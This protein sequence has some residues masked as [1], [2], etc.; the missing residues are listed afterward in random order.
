MTIKLIYFSL[1]GIM[2]LCGTL[3]ISNPPVQPRESIWIGKGL[4][5]IANG[6][7]GSAYQQFSKALTLG[8]ANPQAIRLRHVSDLFRYPYQKKNSEELLEKYHLLSEKYPD[9]IYLKIAGAELHLNSDMVVEALNLN[10]EVSVKDDSHA[11]NWLG[12]GNA[13]Q[14][15]SKHKNALAS[16]QTAFQLNNQGRYAVA[17]AQQQLILGLW[18][19]ALDNFELSESKDWWR[20]SARV[21]YLRT[22][23]YLNRYEEAEKYG[24]SLISFIQKKPSIINKY[25]QNL[26]VIYDKNKLSRVSK[27]TVDEIFSYLRSL[28]EIASKSNTSQELFIDELINETDTR[29]RDVIQYD[30]EVLF[31][32]PRT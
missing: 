13:Y 30:L 28:L 11:S 29:F 16:Y 12:M 10:L 6:S 25:N 14:R 5:S 20:I 3:Q 7:Y 23:I 32:G 9:S 21:G 22:L 26:D 24:S 4:R 17:L 1:F 15:L 2:L 8:T 18:K 31:D 27:A 19:S